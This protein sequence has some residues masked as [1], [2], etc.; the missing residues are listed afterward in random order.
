[1][2]LVVKEVGMPT[3]KPKEKPPEG[4]YWGIDNYKWVLCPRP[5]QE[6]TVKEVGVTGIYE[7]NRDSTARTLVNVGGSGSS[8]SHSIAQVLIEKLRVEKDKQFIISRKTLPS[9][10]RSSYGLII[11]LLKDYGLY[12]HGVHNKSEN[13]FTLGNNVM[14]FFGLDEP[15]KAK[16]IAEGVNYV[17]M[18]EADEFTYDDYTAFRLQVRRHSK[19]KNQI[20]LSFNPIDGEGW[21]PKRL[22]D[23]DGVEVIHSTHLDNP[24]LDA[25]YRKVLEGFVNED[26]NYY[27]VYTLGE[28]GKLDNLI[29]RNYIIVDEFPKELDSWG[30]GLDFGY[31]H[32]TAL[33]KCGVLGGDLYWHEELCE[34]HLTNSDLIEKLSHVPRGDIWADNAEPQ[35]IEEIHRAGY[36][37]YPANKDVKMGIDLCKRSRICITK[38]STTLISQIRGYQNKTDKNGIV[39]EEPVKIKDDT[40]DAGRYGTMGLTERYGFAT[41]KPGAKIG[42]KRSIYF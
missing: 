42:T 28:W 36:N 17:W 14:W 25:D 35:R 6:T 16:S 18:E 26:E 5:I 40:V 12:E 1:M 39:F 33:I 2:E 34:V 21:I 37:I 41:A 4:Y 32:P 11:A 38:G 9:L 29:Y 3:E 27:R 22:M 19:E 15:T 13:T 8:K 30:Y 24:F 10:R 7:R 20:F 23:E 31:V